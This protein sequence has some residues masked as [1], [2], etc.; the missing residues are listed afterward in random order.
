MT[1]YLPYE[2]D[3]DFL[4]VNSDMLTVKDFIESTLHEDFQREMDIRIKMLDNMLDDVQMKY[5]G[6]QYDTFR[7]GKRA[8]IEVKNVFIDILNGIIESREKEKGENDA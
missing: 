6:R 2:T 5:N 4:Q 3:E 1:N 7:G 8:F